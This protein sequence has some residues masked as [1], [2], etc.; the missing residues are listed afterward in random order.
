MT[1]QL[2]SVNPA[3]GEQFDSHDVDDQERVDA[4][5]RLA[6]AQHRMWSTSAFSERSAVLRSAADVLEQRRDALASLMADEMGKPVTAGQAEVDKC[7]W[8]CRYYA[9]HG[10]RLLADESID[11][12]HTKS[13]VRY[14]ALGVV[15]AVMPWNF[16]LWQVFRFAA[17]AIMAGN[18]AVLKHASNVTG[19]S[20][21]IADVFA[22]AGAPE[23]LFASLVLPSSRVAGVIE[24]DL[25]RAVTLTGSGAAGRSVAATAGRAL[26][27]TV[28]ELGGSDPYVVLADADLDHA[29]EVCATSRLLNSGQ[30]C[31]AAKRFVVDDA[32]HDQFLDRLVQQFESKAMGDPQD[33]DTDIGPQ[34]RQDLR[35]E[36]HRQVEAS[37]DAG[38]RLVLGGEVVAGPG[39]FYPPTILA[40]VEPG[41]VAADEE[42]FSPVASVLRAEHADDA[43]RLANATPF[44]LGGA[45]FTADVDRGEAFARKIRA[46]SVAVN[47]MVASDPRLPFGG[48]GESGYGREL[49]SQGIREFTNIKTVVVG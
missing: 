46:G 44:G 37:V 11:T 15:L 49:S 24:H 29:A 3:T 35:D 42:L 4:A 30:S 34:A 48:I 9:D 8:V 1:D 13:Y 36:L 16:P 25:V 38:A 21:Q 45:V 12:E 28:L 43:L 41:M 26:K 6:D 10:E 33:P 32:V 18:G 17:P 14:E 2:I 27:K 39:A 22:E 31:I 47:T 23:G 5:I 19:S 7:A 20:L 40:D